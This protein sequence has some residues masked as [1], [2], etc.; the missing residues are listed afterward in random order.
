MDGYLRIGTELDTKKFDSQ[1]KELEKKIE[2]NK[3]RL[4]R[5][6]KL[7]DL[8]LKGTDYTSEIS[9]LKVNI[10]KDSNKLIDLD[11][12]MK[13][14]NKNSDDMG[15]N[16]SNNIKKGHMSLKRFALSLF[17]LGSIY[18]MVS[19]ASSAYH[20]I[21]EERSKKMQSIWIG[22]GAMLSPISDFITDTLLKGLGY[23]NAF[24]KALTGIDFIANANAKALK[25]QSDAQKALNNQTFSFDEMDKM[26]SNAK[27]SGGSSSGGLIDIPELDQGIINK[28]QEMAH[29]LKENWDWLSKVLIALGV[30]FG[31]AKISKWV[32][33]IGKLIGSG[34]SM[35]GLLGLNGILSTLATIGVIAIGIDLIYK[36][37]TGRDLVKD[38]KDINKGVKDLNGMNKDL[39]ANERAL[40]KQTEKVTNEKNK[41]M[42]TWQKGSM[43]VAQYTANIESAIVSAGN[44]IKRTIEWSNSLNPLDEIMARVTGDMDKN[45]EIASASAKD[46]DILMGSYKKLYDQGLL[47]EKQTERYKTL[48]EAMKNGSHELSKVI[49]YEKSSYANLSTALDNVG[50]NAENSKNKMSLF[51]TAIS[52]IVNKNHKIKIETEFL[53]PDTSKLLNA[54]KSLSGSAF[55]V[56]FGRLKL[57]T[58][59]IVNNP[60]RGVPIGSSA[61]G[62]EAG[63]EGVLP[64]TDSQ[65]M[66][67]L[68]SYIGKYIVVNLTNV[69]ELDGR[70]ISRQQNKVQSI[71][72]FTMNR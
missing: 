37:L 7:Q 55:G 2:H 18:A 34:S 60:G 51:G 40:S 12:K 19:K 36:G 66:E 10:E 15:K 17:S 39:I 45:R 13:D 6:L 4:E 20:S 56:T 69:T 70:V 48:Q 1:Y 5:L 58:G 64:L 32:S 22:L 14:T 68:G 21:D 25:K 28:L 9:N 30:V 50:K 23:L 53:K 35:T 52:G 61:I 43:Q 72:D 54:I 49:D 11:R 29:W 16:I 38:L 44:N 31:I 8:G 63:K 41:E 33:N 26:N 47:N 42:E 59:G 65:A 24:L 3:K 46:I 57:S 27:I 62:G 67:E 71:K